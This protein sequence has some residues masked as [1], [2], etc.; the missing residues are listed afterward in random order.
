MANNLS[1]DLLLAVS[2]SDDLAKVLEK[3]PVA[4]PTIERVKRILPYVEIPQVEHKPIVL[5]KDD[6][7]AYQRIGQ[8]QDIDDCACNRCGN[9]WQQLGTLWDV[10]SRIEN[11][12]ITKTLIPADVRYNVSP[13]RVLKSKK[14]VQCMAC[15]NH[16]NPN[17]SY[18]P[19]SL[20]DLLNIN[21]D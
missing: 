12:V 20:E 6:P 3:K 16:S 9:R 11:G 5:P 15:F 17:D 8:V 18:I 19:G 10:F 21:E 7:N 13:E 4:K 14:T 2:N 1:L